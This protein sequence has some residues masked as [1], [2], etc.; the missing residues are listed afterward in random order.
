MAPNA[1]LHIIR[2]AKGLH[3]LPRNH[4][5][6]SI[7]DPSLTRNGMEQSKQFR[8]RYPYHAS[9]DL[10]CASP[11]RRTIQT[12]SIA[13]EP[14]VQRGLKI[15]A[16]ADAQETTDTPSDTGSDP[17]KLVAEFGTILDL[18]LLGER[19]NDK[20]G[21]NGT[22]EAS[23]WKRA[24]RLRRFLRGRSENDIVLVTHGAFAHYIT[25]HVNPQGHQ[26][27]KSKWCPSEIAQPAPGLD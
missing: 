18:S 8:D 25:E 19:W 12:A 15:L 11:L 13:L 7:R 1:T 27:G 5:N 16:V 9:T 17:N 4:P 10:I 23:I 2:H 14:E 6:I 21:I 22:S 26:T 3:Q 20:S 24:W